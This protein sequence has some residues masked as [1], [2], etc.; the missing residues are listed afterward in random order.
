MRL[1]SREGAGRALLT[2][3]AVVAIAAMATMLGADAEAR[4]RTSMQ[5]K[6]YTIT[7][8]DDRALD[9]QMARLGPPHRGGRAYATLAVDPQYK[10]RLIEG[11]HCRLKDF[12]VTASFVMTLPRLAD[13][14]KLAGPTRGRWKDFQAFVRRHEERHRAIW[15]GCL[16]RA[17]SRA[18]A[19]RVPSCRQLD[20]AVADVFAEEWAKCEKLHDAFDA[21][22]QVRLRRHPLIVAAS[23]AKTVRQTGKAS[24][25]TQ[26]AAQSLI[27]AGR[28]AE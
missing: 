11:S 14:A 13:G 12:T 18:V 26:T 8:P 22:E 28:S 25:S 5:I 15:L 19:L 2:G 24:K 3:G 23:N 4:P 16:A 20:G 9:Q 1:L 7:G 6:Y 10:G 21:A 17:E 27:R